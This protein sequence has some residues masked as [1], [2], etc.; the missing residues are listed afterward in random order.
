MKPTMTEQLNGNQGM[1]DYTRIG[2]GIFLIVM[3]VGI[4]YH[5]VMGNYDDKV[6]LM[7]IDNICRPV[8]NND[9]ICG[10]NFE[11]KYVFLNLANGTKL[12]TDCM[13]DDYPYGH[14]STHYHCADGVWKT[15]EELQLNQE[16]IRD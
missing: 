8:P 2:A 10:M 12:V 3:T 14:N 5:W 11:N 7:S 9:S 13:T 1:R 4:S 15:V 6:D 16:V